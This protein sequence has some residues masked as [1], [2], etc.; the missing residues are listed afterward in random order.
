[1]IMIMIIAPAISIS[2]RNNIYHRPTSM[3]SIDNL[4]ERVQAGLRLT[5]RSDEAMKRLGLK[6]DDIASRSVEDVAHMYNDQETDKAMLEKR[7]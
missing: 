7:W 4:P 5:P 1:M 3:Y 6:L 2:F